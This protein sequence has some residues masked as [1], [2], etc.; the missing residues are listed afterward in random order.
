[1]NERIKAGLGWVGLVLVVAA[2]WLTHRDRWTDF[3]LPTSYDGGDSLQFLGWAKASQE[4][5]YLPLRSK[6]V[7]R[8][9]A[10][11]V[12][13]WN[14]YPIYEEPIIWLTGRLA[15]GIGLF[16]AVNVMQILA[17]VLAAAAF[18]LAAQWLGSGRVW[19]AAGAVVFAF[20]YYMAWRGMDHF[21]L[22]WIWPVPLVVAVSWKALSEPVSRVGLLALAAV[23]G[24]GNSYWLLMTLGLLAGSLIFTGVAAN[25]K[26]LGLAM[27]TGLAAFLLFNLDTLAY[28]RAHGPNP[29]GMPRSYA[30]LEMYALKPVEFFVPPPQHRWWGALGAKYA[31]GV[32]FPGETCSAY[33][34]LAGLAALALLVW[35]CGRTRQLNVACGQVLFVIGASVIG[36]GI[37]VLGLFGMHQFRGGNRM[38]VFVAAIVL[39]FAVRWLGERWPR[40]AWWGRVL[41]AVVVAVAVLDQLPRWPD[42]KPAI[43]AAVAADREVGAA[44]DRL[45]PAGAMVFNLP[46]TRYPE[47]GPVG[48]VSEYDMMRPYLWTKQV[49]FAYGNNQGRPRDHWM[50][51]LQQLSFPEM[52]QWLQEFGFAA[53]YVDKRGVN[54][55]VWE[56]MTAGYPRLLVQGDRELLPL[57]PVARPQLPPEPVAPAQLYSGRQP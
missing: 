36:G 26:W 16:P 46:V 37:H 39:L 27:V 9:G 5:D 3:D 48:L 11:F 44:L 50:F 32:F 41:A 53:I 34:G 49:R 51:S 20:L 40:P 18:Y 57:R 7:S 56:Q 35:H 2:I 1:M 30:Q 13:N 33:L 10:P 42:R 24:A 14:D 52:V 55:P 17:A 6:L 12:A 21:L 31:Q 23:V 43:R 54:A 28:A 29:Q 38:S 4:G 19:G 25:R 47:G 22:T 8:L 45:L 15:N